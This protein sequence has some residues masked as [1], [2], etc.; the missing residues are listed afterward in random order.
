MQPPSLYVID[1]LFHVCHE[2]NTVPAVAA[3][4]CGWVDSAVIE[5][6]AVRAAAVVRSRRPIEAAAADKVELGT[7][8]VALNG[9]TDEAGSLG[10]SPGSSIV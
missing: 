4:V 9:K 10:C 5:A 1:L 6:H 7:I 2:A 8:A 3:V